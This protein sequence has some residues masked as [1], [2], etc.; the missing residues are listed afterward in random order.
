MTIET[1]KEEFYTEDANV[2]GDGSDME[3]L[4][5]SIKKWNG[6]LPENLK[7]HQLAKDYKC[8]SDEDYGLNI[9]GSTCALCQKYAD[10]TT[11]EDEDYNVYDDDMYCYSDKLNQACPIVR[12]TGET[13]DE[14]YFKSLED[15]KLMLD[16]LQFV[17]NRMNDETSS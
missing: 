1:W 3:C 7:K 4:D 11:F 6:V 2:A 13:C 12:V 16:L 5:H 9:D 8:I 15:P 17:K 14:I 10:K